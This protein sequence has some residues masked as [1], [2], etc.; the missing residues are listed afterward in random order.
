M[1]GSS[2]NV[3]TV[4]MYMHSSGIALLSLRGRR[5][6]A[7]VMREEIILFFF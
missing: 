4:R 3:F 2:W 6:R 7:E 1:N 5:I